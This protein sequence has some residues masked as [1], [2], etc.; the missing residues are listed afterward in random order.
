MIRYTS[1]SQPLFCCGTNFEQNTSTSPNIAFIIDHVFNV[2]STSIAKECTIE[3][4]CNHSSK[5]ELGA[6]AEFSLLFWSKRYFL[7]LN[8]QDSHRNIYMCIYM[9]LITRMAMECDNVSQ[10]LFFVKSHTPIFFVNE[11]M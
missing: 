8:D 5:V 11:F 9:L 10:Y 1:I 7:G 4:L 6:E 3:A 2:L